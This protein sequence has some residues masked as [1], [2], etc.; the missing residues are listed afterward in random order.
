MAMELFC[1]TETAETE[2]TEIPNAPLHIACQTKV[3]IMLPYE[4][5]PEWR[6]IK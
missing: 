4:L 3:Y 5:T 1:L 6:S 2:T